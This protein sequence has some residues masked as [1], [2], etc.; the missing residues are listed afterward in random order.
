[1][2]RAAARLPV[3]RTPTFGR[4]DLVDSIVRSLE[5]PDTRLVTLTGLGGSGK[6]RVAAVAAAR[7]RDLTGRDVYFSR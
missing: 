2:P 5:D 4:E 7:V 1:M 6:T 3:P